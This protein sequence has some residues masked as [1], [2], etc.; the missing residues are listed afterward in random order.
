MDIL[1]QIHARDGRF[2][3]RK[4]NGWIIV[5]DKTA[6]Q[7]IAHAIQYRL[8]CSGDKGK[9]FSPLKI[10]QEAQDVNLLTASAPSMVDNC[11]FSDAIPNITITEA[12]ANE[13]P[14]LPSLTDIASQYLP[15]TEGP[16]YV[17]CNTMAPPDTTEEP[18]ACDNYCSDDDSCDC[19]VITMHDDWQIEK[20]DPLDASGAHSLGSY[21]SLMD[22]A[23][24]NENTRLLL[25]EALDL[26]N[27][28][29]QDSFT[30]QNGFDSSSV[31][32]ANS[33]ATRM[34]VRPL[35][36][37]KPKKAYGQG[38]LEQLLDF[39]SQ[40]SLL[41]LL[42]CQEQDTRSYTYEPEMERAAELLKEYYL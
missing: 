38:P 6:R 40:Y 32:P 37:R 25:T 8:R 24:R 28:Y 16:K 11:Y 20:S 26:F 10:A 1:L 31:L 29:S 7:K 22:S 41:R 33:R 35:P 13:L 30:V 42:L 14:R 34:E 36:P 17:L 3:E 27:D 5:S 9:I 12:S 21:H 18:F 39:S 4:S 2:L 15:T 19:S 23:E